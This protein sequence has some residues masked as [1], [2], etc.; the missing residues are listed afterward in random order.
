[1]KIKELRDY[2]IYTDENRPVG[3]I[4]VTPPNPGSAMLLIN[5]PLAPKTG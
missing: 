2:L 1:M 4:I 3:E 5:K